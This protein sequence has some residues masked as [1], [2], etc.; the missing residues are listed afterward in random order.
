[1]VTGAGWLPPSLVPLGYEAIPGKREK[2][3]CFFV[4][5]NENNTDFQLKSLP[6]KFIFKTTDLLDLIP[7][8]SGGLSCPSASAG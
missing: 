2:K 1:M 8:F 4:F 6:S 3:S 7:T 5:L